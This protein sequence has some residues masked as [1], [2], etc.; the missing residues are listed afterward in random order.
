MKNKEQILHTDKI[1]VYQDK[2]LNMRF[3]NLNIPLYQTNFITDAQSILSKSVYRT[4]KL[5]IK[6]IQDSQIDITNYIRNQEALRLYISRQ[7]II[8]WYPDNNASRELNTA[9]EWLNNTS[10]K[11]QTPTQWVNAKLIGEANFSEERGLNIYITPSVLPLYNVVGSN[12]TLLDFAVAMNIQNKA[13]TFFYDKCCK[14]RSVGIF[15]FTPDELQKALNVSTNSTRIRTR[16]IK[17]ADEEI[18]KLFRKGTIDFYFDSY[19]IRSGKGRGGKVDKFVFRIHDCLPGSKKDESQK[20]YMRGFIMNT[21]KELAPNIMS[22]N[23]LQQLKEL[24]REELKDLYNDISYLKKEISSGKIRDIKGVIWMNLRNKYNI[25]INGDRR[26]KKNANYSYPKYTRIGE[27]LIINDLDENDMTKEIE[28]SED[29]YLNEDNSRQIWWQNWLST[30]IYVENNIATEDIMLSNKEKEVIRSLFNAQ[31]NIVPIFDGSKLTINFQEDIFRNY[32]YKPVLP[33]IKGLKEILQDAV[34]TYFPSLQALE[35][36][37]TD[38]NGEEYTMD[39]T[40]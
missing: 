28:A 26:L 14:W 36:S 5:I 35:Y 40:R 8:Q 2:K 3:V 32:I 15:S 25:N 19:E 24:S 10:V 22:D 23:I 17:P 30:I 29:I 33:F 21:I 31:G 7:E 16:Y 18:K 11:Y 12:F 6:K 9:T 1:T 27:E 34:Y 39:M 13:A 37:Y 4:I 20:L 38:H